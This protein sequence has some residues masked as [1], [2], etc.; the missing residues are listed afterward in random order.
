ME[1]HAERLQTDVIIIS[2]SSMF[3]PG[4]P[5]ICYGIRGLAGCQIDLQLSSRDLHSG[6][7]GGTVDNPVQVLTHI[8]SALKDHHGQITIPGFY[9][10]VL[11]L[12]ETERQQFQT[13]DFDED[14]FRETIHVPKLFGEHGYT[15]LER[16]WARPSLDINGILGGF[17]GEGMKTIIPA[18]AM[19]KVTIRLVPNQDPQHILEA[20]KTYVQKLTPP[21]VTL[22]ISHEFGVKP[23]LTPLDHPVIS[24]ISNALK[25]VYKRE[26]V[27]IRSGGTIGVLETFDDLLKAPSV[28]VGFSQPNDNAHAP[29]EHL[30]EDAFYTGI[31]VAARLYS[32]LKEWTPA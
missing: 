21:T 29:N 3:A 22:K 9:D 18:K 28:F 23:Y 14:A 8:L 7:F 31:E 26:P 20:F 27:F 13:L 12:Q 17:A 25:Q 4:E 16:R 5:T 19:A 10:D 24:V 32:E 2:D 11:E 1:Q 15:T 30:D 6:D